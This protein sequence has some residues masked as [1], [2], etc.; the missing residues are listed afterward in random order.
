MLMLPCIGFFEALA[1]QINDGKIQSLRND[2]ET[3]LLTTSDASQ[4]ISTQF[5][6][7]FVRIDPRF[8]ITP[9]LIDVHLP[10][11]PTYMN[12]IRALEVYALQGEGIMTETESFHHPPWNDVVVGIIPI[13]R[14]L[15]RKWAV[16]GLCQAIEYYAENSFV[17]N[18]VF[19]LKWEGRELGKLTFTPR[20]IDSS[21]YAGQSAASANINVT[22]PSSN[23][24][25]DVASEI[26]DNARQTVQTIYLS[27]GRTLSM[28]GILY[29]IIVA[30]VTAFERGRDTLVTTLLVPERRFSASLVAAAISPQRPPPISYDFESFAQASWDIAKFVASNNVYAE[31][32]AIVSQDDKRV[33]TIQGRYLAPNAYNSTT[34][35]APLGF[36]T[37]V[38]ATRSP[39]SAAAGQTSQRIET[40]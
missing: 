14:N 16:W 37:D 27:Q 39:I 34:G 36:S 18:G 1:L 30:L 31:Y 10:T 3:Q 26:P 12:V 21:D 25:A 5:I 9:D 8:S 32:D 17:L 20:K 15:Q 35:T 2:N 6:D 13:R 33:G 11:L 29:P 19:Y 28:L 7:A 23:S 4:G 40:Y 38:N 24:T 22:L